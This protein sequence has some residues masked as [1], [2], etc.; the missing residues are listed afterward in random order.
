MPIIRSVHFSKTNQLKL[1]LFSIHTRYACT[2]TAFTIHQTELKFFICSD[3]QCFC[4]SQV[5]PTQRPVGG[6]LREACFP[7]SVVICRLCS[8]TSFAVNHSSVQHCFQNSPI[9]NQSLFPRLTFQQNVR[10]GKKLQFPTDIFR[11]AK[12]FSFLSMISIFLSHGPFHF[13]NF[14]AVTF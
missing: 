14:H 6:L 9:V 1:L 2:L 12:K 8:K 7:Y 3:Y 11:L 10:Y 5:A 13:Q 4:M